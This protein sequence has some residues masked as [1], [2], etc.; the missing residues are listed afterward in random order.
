MVIIDHSIHEGRSPTITFDVVGSVG[1]IYKVMVKESPSCDCPD[2]IFRRGKCKHIFYGKYSV[3]ADGSALVR[4]AH[5][6]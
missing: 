3:L 5:R 1:N 6:N 4:F 2:F